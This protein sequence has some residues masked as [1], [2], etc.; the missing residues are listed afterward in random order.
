MTGSDQIDALVDSVAIIITGTSKEGFRRRHVAAHYTDVGNG[1][2]IF[3]DVWIPFSQ[4]P[5][6]FHLYPH[7]LLMLFLDV[8]YCRRENLSRQQLLVEMIG[9]YTYLAFLFYELFFSETCFLL[10]YHLFP[11]LINQGAQIMG[12]QICHSGID[13]RN[14]FNSNGLFDWREA[15][16]LFKVSLFLIES[17]SN[18]GIS[19]HGIHHAHTQI[20]LYMINKHLREINAYAIKTY[21]YVRYNNVLTFALYGDILPNIPEPKWYDYIIQSLLIFAGF[22]YSGFILMGAPLPPTAV[23]EVLIVDYRFYFYLDRADIWARWKVFIQYIQAMARRELLV[24]PNDYLEIVH[25]FD[26][27]CDAYL[28]THK[29]KTPVPADLTDKVCPKSVWEF[30]VGKPMAALRAQTENAKNE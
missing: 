3:S 15:K 27:K 5:S 10:V 22:C 13:K 26:Q 24:S 28:A 30:N 11:Q 17:F 1:A 12:A 9:F 4:F 20:P 16:G 29:V 6:T 19:N 25:K 21:S 18:G 23:F 8:E 2:R 7:K 14:S